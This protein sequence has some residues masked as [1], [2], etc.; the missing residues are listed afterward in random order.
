VAKWLLPGQAGRGSGPSLAID[1][2][3]L[4][5]GE[6]AVALE[7][8]LEREVEAGE[9][10]DGGELGHPQRYLDPPFSRRV[11]SSSNRVS[12]WCSCTANDFAF[13]TRAGFALVEEFTDPTEL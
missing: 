5:D 1:E 8:R 11:N 7:G 13:A 9:G 6:N 4:G 10:L 2:G 3:E 12:S